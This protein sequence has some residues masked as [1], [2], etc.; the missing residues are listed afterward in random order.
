MPTNRAHVRITGRSKD[1]SEVTF[2]AY[3]DLASRLINAMA[4]TALARGP[5]PID[6]RR[7]TLTLRGTDMVS[8]INA[9]LGDDAAN[10]RIS[11][12]ETEGWPFRASGS[13][14]RVV[15]GSEAG[16]MVIRDES[17]VIE[18]TSWEE[19]AGAEEPGL[20]GGDASGPTDT[21]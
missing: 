12:Q 8:L 17:Y 4:A 13:H 21:A 10:L 16:R 2:Q 20:I 5:D 11:V 6:R 15:D 19:A 7:F 9:S 1:A 14:R 18:V 3:D